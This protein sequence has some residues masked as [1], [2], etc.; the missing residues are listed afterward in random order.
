MPWQGSPAE[1]PADAKPLLT[2]KDLKKVPKPDE[3]LLKEK[4]AEVDSK[5]V[6][7]QARL[8]VIKETLDSHE[9]GRSEPNSE[10]ALAKSKYNEIRQ[11]ARRLQQECTL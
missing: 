8:S 6:E 5:I 1:A 10:L 9:S 11:E 3:G 4:I 2:E 7:L